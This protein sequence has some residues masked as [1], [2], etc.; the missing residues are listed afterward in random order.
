MFSFFKSK[1]P[2]KEKSAELFDLDHRPIR[3]GDRVLS[4]RYDMGECRVL[5]TE[6]GIEYESLSTGLRK[7]WIYMIDAAT[8][9]QK[10][11]KLDN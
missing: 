1:K 2:A 3:E 11:R 8:E 10:V 6:S 7:S 4:L 5:R 9:L